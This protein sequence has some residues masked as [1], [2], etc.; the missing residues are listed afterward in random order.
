MAVVYT[1]QR[2][3]SIGPGESE[4][5]AR[6]WFTSPDIEQRSAPLRELVE[7]FEPRYLRL[8]ARRGEIA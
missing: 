2:F 7:T 8:R 3:L 5:A 4:N 1:P 6:A